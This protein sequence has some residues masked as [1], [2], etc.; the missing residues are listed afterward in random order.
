MNK[1]AHALAFAA[2][3]LLAL[4]AAAKDHN[5]CYSKKMPGVIIFTK[6]PCAPG[7][8]AKE[9]PNYPRGGTLPSKPEQAPVAAQGRE[10]TAIAS[11]RPVRDSF[12]LIRI[13]MGAPQVRAMVGAPESI[14][15]SNHGNGASEQWVYRPNGDFRAHYI[16]IENGKVRSIQISR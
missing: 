5:M 7:M 2:A 8:K 9:S 12:D 1:T 6:A 15:A 10:G 14:N 3:A 13:G 11:N 16:Y 4:P